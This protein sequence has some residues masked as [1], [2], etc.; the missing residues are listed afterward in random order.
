VAGQGWGE[1]ASVVS[2]RYPTLWDKMETGFFR[3]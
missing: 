3:S 1:D 2:G